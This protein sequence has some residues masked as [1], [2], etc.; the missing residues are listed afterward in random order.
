LKIGKCFSPDGLR[1]EA[2][3]TISRL[4]CAGSPDHRAQF[5]FSMQI[6]K[7]PV[8]QRMIDVLSD[9]YRHPGKQNLFYSANSSVTASDRLN[10]MSYWDWTPQRTQPAGTSGKANNTCML[11]LALGCPPCFPFPG[12]EWVKPLI[13]DPAQVDA[14][15]V[16]DVWEGRAGEILQELKDQLAALP[17]GEII[18]APDI[19]SP[20]GVAELMWDDSF[21]TTLFDEPEAVHRL[22]EK[23]TTFTI[24]FVKEAQRLLGSHSNGVGFPLIWGESRGTMIADDTMS[25]ISPAMHSEF[26]V[27]YVN[28][29]ADACGPIYY[30]SCTWRQPY[31]DNIHK[32]RNVLAYNWNPGNSDDPAV[33]MREFSGEAMLTPHIQINMH[34]D[35]D[36]LGFGFRDE[37]D[38]LRY[39]MENMQTNTSMYFWFSAVVTKA[40]V[41]EAMYDLLHSAGYTP[42]AWGLV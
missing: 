40:D 20:M 14:L 37:T 27:P 33:I 38:L 42:E 39:M 22:L 6:P 8:N 41:L 11:P 31:F 13:T 26:S 19:Q 12:K 36:L 24:A 21:Y 4:A 17:E 10:G 25:L 23:I 18:R 34:K 29:F 32:I 2:I 30:H 7:P 28:Q 16:P 1:K 9:A 15:V 5:L 3:E 35:N